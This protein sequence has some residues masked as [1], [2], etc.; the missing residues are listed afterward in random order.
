MLYLSTDK[1]GFTLVELLVVISMIT[2]L[3]SII[4]A[5]TSSARRKADIAAGMRFATY[6]NRAFYIGAYFYFDF[7]NWDTSSP[8]EPIDSTR[9]FDP[10]KISW[11]NGIAC[12]SDANSY[13][14]DAKNAILCGTNKG[15]SL[16]GT[17]IIP[18]NW[19][20]ITLSTWFK[21][22]GTTGA[23]NA[24]ILGAGGGCPVGISYGGGNN[25]IGISTPSGI[26]CIFNPSTFSLESGKW[27]HLAVSFEGMNSKLY[28]NGQLFKTVTSA[29]NYALNIS[30]SDT[31][32]IIG[33][34][35]SSLATL[36][37][38]GSVDDSAIYSHALTSYEVRSIYALT[39]PEHGI[40]RENLFAENVK[41]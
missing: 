12:T 21:W 32:Y 23:T 17:G 10:S 3:S 20:N 30:Q 34:A 38:N 9:N 1:K 36:D 28:I 24:V 40:S 25:N 16:D 6:N 7:D 5:S 13:Y 31:K 37:A 4:F 18:K 15:L 8:A 22:N 14:P 35:G 26:G 39:A 29:S 11:V 2:F 33:G 41:K 19:D 27:Y